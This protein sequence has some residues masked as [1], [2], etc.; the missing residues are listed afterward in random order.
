MIFSIDCSLGRCLILLIVQGGMLMKISEVME[1]TS[2]TK[3]AI[4]YYE[5]EELIKPDVNSENNYREYSKDDID[6]LVQISVLRQFDVP[7]R[8]IK[9]IIQKPERL[10]EVLKQHLVRMEDEAKRLEKSTNLLRSCL[11]RF[12]DSKSGISAF[13]SELSMLNKSLETDERIKEGFMKRQ[14]QR[15]FPGNF[16]R[17]MIS[18][19]SAFLNEPI[20]TEEKEKA[21]VSL[22]KFLDEAGSIEYSKEMNRIYEALSEE[23]MEKM[24]CFQEAYVKKWISITPEQVL[25]E[26]NTVLG[27]YNKVNSDKKNQEEW[28]EFFRM[29]KGLKEKMNNINYYN[30]FNENLKILSSDYCKYIRNRTDFCKSLNIKVD[31]EGKMIA[32]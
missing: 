16:G 7:V 18:N 14:L 5:E 10:K 32:K 30:S 9:M 28:Q 25:E 29:S 26:K 31:D 15:I 4:N 22:V 3:K 13:T 17:M 11:N 24:T 21:W 12:D 27:F 2:L 8:E 23:D 1:I 19:Y 20:D 6:K